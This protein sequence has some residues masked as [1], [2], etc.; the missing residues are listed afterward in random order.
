MNF[1]EFR[2]NLNYYLLFKSL[3]IIFN[4]IFHILQFFLLKFVT[5]L[6]CFIARNFIIQMIYLILIKGFQKYI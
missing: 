4:T 2:F 1:L 3:I 5:F 6:K